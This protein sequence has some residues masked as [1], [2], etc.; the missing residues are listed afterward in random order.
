MAL[1]EFDMIRRYFEPVAAAGALGDDCAVLSLAP[2]HEL[3]ISTDTLV[4]GVHFPELSD[5]YELAWRSMGCCLSDLAAMGAEPLGYTLALTLPE[6]DEDWLAAFCHGLHAAGDLYRV[7]LVGGDT[8]RGPLTLTLTV[9]G[10]T[11]IGGALRRQGGRP[12]DRV[13][14]S[15]ALGGAGAALAYLE[16]PEQAPTLCERYWRPQP[17]LALGRALRGLATAAIDIS[18]GLAADLGH[19]CRASG[20]G[21]ELTLQAIPMESEA[22]VLL[23]ADQ[24]MR[25][26]LSGGDDYEL[27][28]TVPAA[29]V[30][31]VAGLADELRVPLTEVGVLE[32]E[33]GL[34]GLK[35]GLSADL[36]TW[37]PRSGYQ[38][39]GMS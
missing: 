29:R 36:S 20:C 23:G 9:M 24:A 5:P 25:W 13:F 15:G 2:R 38:H 35:D 17:R 3:N 7:P 37:L 26:A 28:F 31:E 33:P 8:T 6:A 18:D 1:T 32:T 19:L 11:P 34:R 10:Q 22:I 30:E 12:G 21:A 27:C 16:H 14:V 4:R 39:F